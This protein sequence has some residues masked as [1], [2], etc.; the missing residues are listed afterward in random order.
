MLCF[1]VAPSV[2]KAL[3]ADRGLAPAS[4]NAASLEHLPLL[5][6]SILRPRP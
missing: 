1:G 5:T 6:L 4:T 3:R 2:N